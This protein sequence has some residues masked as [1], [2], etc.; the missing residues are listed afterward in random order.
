MHFIC[1]VVIDKYKINLFIVYLNFSSL[2]VIKNNSKMTTKKDACKK[3]TRISL[4]AHN[5]FISYLSIIS[6][7]IFRYLLNMAGT[8][9]DIKISNAI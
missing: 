4:T 3:Y 2:S 9:F 5:Y 1:E 8:Y 6:R 7:I